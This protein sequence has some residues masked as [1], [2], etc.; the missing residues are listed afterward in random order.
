MYCQFVESGLVVKL[1]SASNIMIN[2]VVQV[3]T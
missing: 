2:C 1:E 3:A